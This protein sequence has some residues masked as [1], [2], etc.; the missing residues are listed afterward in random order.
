MPINGKQLSIPVADP[1]FDLPLGCAGCGAAAL[2]VM[3]EAVEA[4]VADAVALSIS[5]DVTDDEL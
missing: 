1:I 3:A 4:S 2:E 5:I